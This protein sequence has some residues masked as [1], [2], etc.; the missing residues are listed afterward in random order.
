MLEAL[1]ASNAK[2]R[3]NI[4]HAMSNVNLE[5][6]PPPVGASGRGAGNMLDLWLQGADPR[7]DV[8]MQGTEISPKSGTDHP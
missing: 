5:Y 1:Y 8:S 3:G 6:L 7:R 2:V 4:F